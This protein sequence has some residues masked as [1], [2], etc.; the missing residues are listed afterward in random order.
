ML[1]V[2]NERAVFQTNSHTLA[3]ALGG[4]VEEMGSDVMRIDFGGCLVSGM[5]DIA[6]AVD[7]R[8]YELLAHHLNPLVTALHKG[9]AEARSTGIIYVVVRGY[10]FTYAVTIADAERLLHIIAENWNEYR[11]LEHYN[12]QRYREAMRALSGSPGIDN[13]REIATLGATE[14]Q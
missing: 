8:R 6:L 11:A 14:V 2:S 12:H 13:R 7:D 4:D 10:P 5:E 1:F 9:V 3:V